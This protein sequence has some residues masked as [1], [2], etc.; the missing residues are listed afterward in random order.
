MKILIVEDDPGIVDVLDHT[1]RQEG[2][3][4]T[5]AGCGLPDFDGF[6]VCRPLSSGPTP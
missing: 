2:H 1:L 3:A 5:H 6:E 4:L